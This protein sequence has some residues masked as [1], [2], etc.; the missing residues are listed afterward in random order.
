MTILTPNWMDALAENTLLLSLMTLNLCL[1][2]I[3]LIQRTR[4]TTKLYGIR[5]GALIFP[6]LLLGSVINGVAAL[7]AIK[8]F[9]DAKKYNKTDQIVWDKTEHFFPS[10]ESLS[11]TG[12][13]Q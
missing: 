12:T 10:E 6:R 3:R 1:F 7:K 9:G 11:N 4:F 5:H 2:A 8:Q 13:L